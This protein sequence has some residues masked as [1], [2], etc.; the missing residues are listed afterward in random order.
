MTLAVHDF[1]R[2][3]ASTMLRVP[4]RLARPGMVLA[5][6]IKH[7]ARREQVLLRAGFTLDAPAVARLR[8]LNIPDLWIQYPDLE[9]IGRY[10]N[11]EIMQGQ[12]ELVRTVGDMFTTLSLNAHAKL[13]YPAYRDMIRGFLDKLMQ[14]PNAA[15][16]LSELGATDK[17]LLR[18]SSNVCYLSLL[19]GLTLD[20]Y[21][22]QQR[23]RLPSHRAKDVVNL[24]VGALLHDVGMTRLDREVVERWNATHDESDEAWQEHVT[25]GH[26]MVQGSVE[27]SAASV[28]LHHHQRFDGLGIPRREEADG[29]MRGLSG[30]RIHVYARIVAAADLFDRLR[31]P[32]GELGANP[33][34]RALRLMQE[35]EMACR[36]DPMAFRALISV[37]PPYAP[38]SLVGLS[39]GR[40][41]VVKEWSI[42]DPCRPTVQIINDL[43][44]GSGGRRREA[45][46]EEI[47]LAAVDH[48]L[49]ISA[50][51]GSDVS[52][53]NF[54][55]PEPGAFAVPEVD[56]MEVG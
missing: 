30:E 33:T 27:P 50:A 6:A 40:Q 38:G 20:G 34:V 52:A 43:L 25:I 2:L 17:P 24:G 15:V 31:H 44:E 7:P 36:I 16:L 42:E 48:A 13:D 47:N 10:I 19:M 51:E 45:A 22:V 5:F 39:D 26:A 35:P 54:S 3:E 55:P 11:P 49:F 8:E 41:A 29:E 4:M 32:P 37:A 9:F 1:D 12:D 53:D 23:S 18:H 14:N 46:P 56:R 21:L 28:I